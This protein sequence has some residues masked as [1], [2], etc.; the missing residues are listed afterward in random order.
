MEDF[1][2]NKHIDGHDQHDK[3]KKLSLS[4]GGGITSSRLL[5]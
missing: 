3:G 5:S 1:I 4:E 2:R